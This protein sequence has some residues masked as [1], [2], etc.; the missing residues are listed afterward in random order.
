MKKR[1]FTLSF[2]F[3][4]S[5]AYAFYLI[6]FV[7]I[8]KADYSSGIYY[9]TPS[10]IFVFIKFF[11]TGIKKIKSVVI[12][13]LIPFLIS[14]Y[15]TFNYIYAGWEVSG[16][17]PAAVLASYLFK[18]SDS[19]S[20]PLEI[21][22]LPKII[23]FFLLAISLF[24]CLH[25]FKTDSF[26][27]SLFLMI[28]I[29]SPAPLAVAT[30]LFIN[31]IISTAA[32]SALLNNLKFFNN[33]ALISR[34]VFDSDSFLNLPHLNLSGVETVKDLTKADF[35]KMVEKLNQAA[36]N[37]ADYLANIKKN[38]LFSHIFEDGIKLTMAP[39]NV[40][41]SDENYGKGGLVLPVE[42][43]NREFIA[44]A[45]DARI[46]GYYEIDKIEPSTNL[47]FLEIFVKRYGV[48]SLIID[49]KKP[50]FWKRCEI[51]TSFDR[52]ELSSSDL[53][54]SEN[55]RGNLAATEVVWGDA[56]PNG[57]DVFLAKPFLTTLLNLILISKNIGSRL[58]RGVV[59]CSIPF[60]AQLF[61]IAFGVKLPQI[62]AVCILLSF[63]STIFYIFY[64]KPDSK[65]KNEK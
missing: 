65:G 10:Y 15:L 60:F 39:L 21:C 16:F 63:T 53:V 5:I 3:Y 2:F 17:I 38:R 59:L 52:V 47:A 9:F 40:L 57:G 8:K 64:I 54:I 56:D 23:N 34:L 18:G 19:G 61:A 37:D 31:F 11:S 50:N 41:L 33:G 42:T 22:Y 35:L 20:T 48:K 4:A 32:I 36:Q 29:Y 6:Y 43:K 12:F 24:G 7:F 26:E 13:T 55:Y 1:D 25:F 51:E 44:L 46:V 30:A 62:S 58:E 28:S 14:L 27:E 45:K 49:P